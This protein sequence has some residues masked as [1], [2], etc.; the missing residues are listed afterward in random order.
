M[1]LLTS[2]ACATTLPAPRVSEPMPTCIRW[3]AE[4]RYRPYGYDHVV[5][6]HNSCTVLATCVVTTD[7]NPDPIHAVVP[8]QSE[9]EVVTW[10]GAPAREFTPSVSCVLHA[11]Q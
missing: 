9:I 8:A 5:H 6:I 1:L 3:A 11:A 10:V 2:A 7:V 4:S